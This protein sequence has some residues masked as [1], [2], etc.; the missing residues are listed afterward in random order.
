MKVSFTILAN[1]I[2]EKLGSK[3]REGYALRMHMLEL[4]DLNKDKT[5]NHEHLSQ[6]NFAPFI[7]VL[8]VFSQFIN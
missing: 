7:V 3:P 8:T 2:Q 4:H 6:K 1:N 5:P